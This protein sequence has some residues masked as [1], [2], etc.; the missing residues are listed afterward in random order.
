MSCSDL[1]EEQLF[2]KVSQL[3]FCFSLLGAAQ[4]IAP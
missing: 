4:T 3:L 2:R 1:A